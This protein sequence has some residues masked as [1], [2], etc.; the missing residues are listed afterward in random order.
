MRKTAG[1]WKEY[2]W[3]GWCIGSIIGIWPRFIEP[4]LLFKT[5]ITLP[6]PSLPKELDGLKIA[7]FSDLHWSSD[8]PPNLAK[9]LIKKIKEFEPDLICFTGDFLS[10]SQL[11][12]KK[13]LNQFLN[14]FE[15][16]L[17]CFAILGNHDYSR[18]VTVNNKGHYDVEAPSQQSII[19][20]G[21]QRLFSPS[22]LSGSVTQEAKE[23][24]EHKELVN[25]LANT[26]FKLL[27]N[28]TIVASYQGKNI[29]ISGLEE[30]SLGRCLLPTTFSTYNPN[31]PGIILSHNPDTIPLF[32][33]YPGD[34]ILCGHTH[35]GQVNLPWF[36]KKFTKIEH[37]EYKKGLKKLKGVTK[38]KWAYINRG[39]SSV[40]PFRWFAPPEITFIELTRTFS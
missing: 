21:F 17:G 10:C 1:K 32:E 16:P 22:F 20:K 15:A 30:Y 27:R 36:W 31:Y 24:S 9:K 25:L 28:E 7:H 6:I 4:H 3:N 37:P 33:N 11:E 40:M 23:I 39:L 12:N 38:E 5:K 8:F 19:S 2:L 29:N 26:P 14:S 35:G 13:E 18:F 34:L